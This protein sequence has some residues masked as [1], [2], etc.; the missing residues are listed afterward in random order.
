MR[1]L[2]LI[3]G[4]VAVTLLAACGAPPSLDAGEAASIQPSRQR[5]YTAQIVVADAEGNKS[6][7]IYA[8]GY[9]C[10]PKAQLTYTEDFTDHSGALKTVIIAQ[11]DSLNRRSLW[12]GKGASA[13][14][15]FRRNELTRNPALSASFRTD[16]T[17]T[18]KV[19]NTT[20]STD[21]S[22]R[23]RNVSVE[24]SFSQV[25]TCRV[26]ALHNEANT[27]KQLPCSINLSDA[28]SI[29]EASTQAEVAAANALTKLVAE[30][31]QKVDVR[32]DLRLDASLRNVAF[33]NC[34]G[35]SDGFLIRLQGGVKG[36]RGENDFLYKVTLDQGTTASIKS[37]DGL[38]ADELIYCPTEQNKA[39]FEMSVSALEL[40]LIYNDTYRPDDTRFTVKRTDENFAKLLTFSRV[41]YFFGLNG[42]AHRNKVLVEVSPL[43][44]SEAG[45]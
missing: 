9:T 23:T 4:P 44:P 28:P 42:A 25:W 41:L 15:K 7:K 20:Y 32:L 45:K 5:F 10:V 39:F 26:D 38:V 12:T 21:G 36:H 24:R 22:S 2:A 17:R 13:E 14:I 19:P 6:K 29:P 3:A 11:S 35:R 33:D 1:R 30:R 16:C 18:D 27:A 34:G 40:D 37:K 43:N 31:L 8:D